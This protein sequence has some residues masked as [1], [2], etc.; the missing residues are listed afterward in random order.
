MEQKKHSQKFLRQR[1][2]IMVM[3]LLILPFI[4]L[5]FWA[6]DGG[7]VNDADAQQTPGRF[8]MQLPGA[9]FKDDK[10]LD[11][12]SYY[13]KAAS[14]SAKFQELVKN[15]PSYIHSEETDTSIIFRNDYSLTDKKYNAYKNSHSNRS[16]F[17]NS[18]YQDP[19]EAK[20]YK[21][22]AELNTALNNATTQET[23]S[24]YEKDFQP[25]NTTNI[26]DKDVDRL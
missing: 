24:D 10:P 25:A 20:V 23:K 6:F 19:N 22:L 18:S 7:K 11:K 9:N 21:K 14:D 2:F 4:T 13:E 1:K 16:T 15:D 3:P 26:N 5:L 12:L 17:N 8:N